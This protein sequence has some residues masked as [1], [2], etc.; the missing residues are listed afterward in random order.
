MQRAYHTI[1]PLWEMVIL[2]QKFKIDIMIILT[3]FFI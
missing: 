2:L 1:L 3:V